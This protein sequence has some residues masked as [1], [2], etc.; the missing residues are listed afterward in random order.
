MTSIADP[1]VG[2]PGSALCTE[3]GLCCT[4]ALHNFAVL[5]PDE[6]DFA[7]SIGL[8]L[9][10]EGRPGFALPCPHLN[11]STCTIYADRPKVCARYKCG[12]L[13]RLEAG[14]TSFD[15]ALATVAGA[16]ELVD[17]AQSAMPDGMTIPAARALSNE[18]PTTGVNAGER[19]SEMRL[20]LAMMALNLFLDK[21]FK[22]DR[23]GKQLS[24]ET[25]ANSQP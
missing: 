25:I 23:E 9:R 24:F 18:P 5:D 4:G 11:Q 19:T 21:H 3:C 13:E 17:R 8:T 7:R 1:V 16:K 22:N 6:I 15:A 12:L 14:S 20:R 10:I 2:S